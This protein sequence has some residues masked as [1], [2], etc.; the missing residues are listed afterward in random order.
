[1]RR[2]TERTMNARASIDLRSRIGGALLVLIVFAS[3]PA[4]SRT[5]R[6]A[7]VVG[8]NGAAPGRSPLRYAHKDAENI[9]RVLTEVAGFAG[10]DIEILLDPEPKAVEDALDRALVRLGEGGREPGGGDHESLLFFYYSGHADG[11]AFYPSGQPLALEG[12][13]ERLTDSRAI[14]RV[15]VIDT[16]RGGGWTGAKGLTT[17]D[18]FPIEPPEPIT[19]EGSVLIA[20]SAGAE[21]AHEAEAVG[22]SFFTHHFAAALRGAA[23]GNNDGAVTISEAYA[24]ARKLTVRDAALYA[25]DPQHPSFH[26]ELRGRQ[27]VAFARQEE[28]RSK[29]LLSDLRGPLEI[30]HVDS[31]TTLLEVFDRQEKLTLALSPGAYILRRRQGD[32]IWI[33]E[34]TVR[35]GTTLRITESDFVSAELGRLSRKVYLQPFR[36][37][38]PLVPP[39]YGDVRIA[40]GVSHGELPG[41]FSSSSRGLAGIGS[42]SFGLT[43]DL[44][45]V[46]PGVIAFRARVLEGI[47]VFPWGGLG[48][49]GVGASSAEGA[50]LA[51]DLRSGVDARWEVG[52][53]EALVFGVDLAS[54]GYWSQTRSDS[55]ETWRGGVHVGYSALFADVVGIHVGVSARSSW[56]LDGALVDPTRKEANFRMGLGSVVDLAGRRWPLIQLHVTE[57]LAI[58]GYAAIESTPRGVEENY[59]LG[60]TFNF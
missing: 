4:F 48:G 34:F 30:I 52:R 16:C 14:V 2:A 12:I 51:L 53:D 28:G 25:R 39:G 43:D 55:F 32:R 33:R 44:M 35:S 11:R 23:D 31:G 22:G 40:L 37:A 36:A 13:K 54:P 7:V 29:V 59:L 15:G 50:I 8:A 42:M 58:D 45:L 27:D 17:E 3:C 1:M 60:A 47:D 46:L 57:F 41:G 38:R 26:V 19:S 49:L 9:A 18:A 21:S 24:Y 6:R 5:A 56:L 20:S 10:E